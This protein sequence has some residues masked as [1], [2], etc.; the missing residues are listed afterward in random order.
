MFFFFT[1]SA[2]NITPSS[3]PP[4]KT[5]PNVIHYSTSPST[6]LVTPLLTRDNYVSWSRAVTMALHAKSKLDFVD[7]SL[8]IPKEKDNISNWE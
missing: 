6:V 2:T 5:D 1:M 8:P 3:S 4:I 7:G